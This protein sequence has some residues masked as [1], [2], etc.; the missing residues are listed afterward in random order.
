M[1]KITKHKRANSTEMAATASNSMA[2]KSVSL[3]GIVNNEYINKDV[4][5]CRVVKIVAK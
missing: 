3:V 2:G 4:G 1:V 5:V